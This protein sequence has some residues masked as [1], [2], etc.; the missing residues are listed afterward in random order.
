MEI[1]SYKWHGGKEQS[2][3]SEYGV[4]FLRRYF[5]RLRLFHFMGNKAE[6][7]ESDNKLAKI[8]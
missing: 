6:K 8:V 7:T 3:E 1:C 5:I 2:A 4:M